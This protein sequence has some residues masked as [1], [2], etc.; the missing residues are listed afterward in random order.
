MALKISYPKDQF[1]NEVLEQF[2]E[3]YTERDGS[4]VL[5]GIT[6]I[7]TEADTSRLQAALNA[8]KDAH[9]KTKDRL[10]PLAL[11]GHSV[12][13]MG[14]DELK[15][16]IEAFDGYDELKTKAESAG[17]IDEDKLNGIVEQRIKTRL[18]PVEREKLKLIEDL[19]A[20]TEQ[21]STY[22]AK[23]RQRTIHDEVRKARQVAKIIDSAEEDVLILA[24][25]MFD[26]GEDGRVTT[27]DSVGVTPGITPDI[28][29]QEMQPKRPHWWPESQ[30]G[31]AK[32][33][34][35]GGFAGDNP[36]SAAHWNLTKQG[37]ILSQAGGEAKAEQMAKAAGSYI[38]ATAPPKGN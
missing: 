12:V 11:N 29:L 7:K 28:W 6:G 21:V 36:W 38:G 1:E 37:Q 13:E 3:L 14:D 27:K 35:G 20:A 30:G 22:Q 10:R 5:T 33:G 15:T 8:E 26:V 25:R 23:E 19:K 4:F 9:K 32:G 17:Q 18:A 16:A 24:E 31:G 34:K 2:R